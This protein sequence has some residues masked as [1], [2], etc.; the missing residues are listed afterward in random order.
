ML[1][2]GGVLVALVAA[3]IGWGV[4]RVVRLRLLPT[5]LLAVVTFASTAGALAMT[6]PTANGTATVEVR[7]PGFGE[8]IAAGSTVVSGNVRPPTADVVVA[9]RSEKDLNWWLWPVEK[10][11]SLD[12]TTGSWKLE[13]QLGAGSAGIEE[14]FQIVALAAG[15]PWHCRFRRCAR[16]VPD[17]KQPSLPAWTRSEPLTV[18]RIEGKAPQP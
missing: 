5:G 10:S 13:V 7:T 9:L 1:T 16:V 4:G 12:P 6:D 15:L 3:L 8:L 17:G 14:N 11:G 2:I 18:R